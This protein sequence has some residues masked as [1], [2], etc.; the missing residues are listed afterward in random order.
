MA[1]ARQHTRSREKLPA[2][3]P[4]RTPDE[5]LKIEI[6]PKTFDSDEWGWIESV[7]GLTLTD[8]MTGTVNA[9]AIKAMVF[10]E[11]RRADP[12]FT[13]AQAGRQSTVD[14]M[15]QMT[16]GDDD[17]SAEDDDAGDESFEASPVEAEFD[18][19]EADVSAIRTA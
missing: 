4:I 17:D 5:T 19:P 14:M 10:L 11:G 15:D 9:R 3:P 13:W 2:P 12:D 1:K 16:F 7:S 6:D 8:V 18:E